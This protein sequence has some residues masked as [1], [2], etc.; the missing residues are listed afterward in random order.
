M[1][2]TNVIFRNFYSYLKIQN[3]FIDLFFIFFF[4][5]VTSIRLI[6]KTEFWLLSILTG[7]TRPRFIPKQTRI[8]HNIM[9]V[10]YSCTLCEF[11]DAN[12]TWFSRIRNCCRWHFL[13]FIFWS[14]VNYVKNICSPKTARHVSKYFF[15][16]F[17]NAFSSQFYTSPL[18]HLTSTER[19]RYGLSP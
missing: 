3:C 9:N 16:G 6:A 7:F 4:F 8:I 5:N 17:L 18:C 11:N 14:Y 19:V 1:Y 12:A 10:L 2:I 13:F 15:Y